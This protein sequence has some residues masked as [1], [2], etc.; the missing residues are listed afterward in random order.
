[1][2]NIMYLQKSQCCMGIEL[3]RLYT[4]GESCKPQMSYQRDKLIVAEMK[5]KL[6]RIETLF[7]E[8]GN[9]IQVNAE[10]LAVNAQR[11]I[12][13]KAIAQS[14]SDGVSEVV[15]LG[16]GR[17]VRRFIS[18]K[19]EGG[20]VIPGVVNFH[21]EAKSLFRKFSL[22]MSHML[23]PGYRQKFAGYCVN[24]V[25]CHTDPTSFCINIIASPFSKYLCDIKIEIVH[26]CKAPVTASDSAVRDKNFFFSIE[27]TIYDD[28]LFVNFIMDII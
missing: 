2:S 6:Q 14:V 1:M 20:I 28:T 10:Q 11:I 26:P 18:M 24:I 16:C 19:P 17:G 3:P 5:K 15:G 8:D 9:Q 4:C 23:L 25:P 13:T 21:F 7:K 22:R 12:E 27:D